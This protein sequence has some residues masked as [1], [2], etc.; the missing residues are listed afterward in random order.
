MNGATHARVTIALLTCVAFGC[1]STPPAAPSSGA[2]NPASPNTMVPGGC[3][4]D[5]WIISW[6][7]DLDA[8]FNDEDELIRN[9]E[10]HERLE[11][12]SDAEAIRSW[13]DGAPEKA[14]KKPEKGYEFLTDFRVV[15]RITSSH[16]SDLVGVNGNCG[17]VRRNRKQFLEYDPSLL[18]AL[19]QPLSGAPRRELETY[20]SH[21]GC[22]PKA[23]PH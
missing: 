12:C 15:A 6:N 5:V 7:T 10:V 14:I 22:G 13:L 19:R 8:G 9:A 16:G 1:A 23:P 4:V 3:T 17:W 18:K 20:L 2:P 11:T 21:A